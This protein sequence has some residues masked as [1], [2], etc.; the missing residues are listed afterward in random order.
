MAL[1]SL[2]IVAKAAPTYVS[3]SYGVDQIQF[4]AGGSN[5][6]NSAGYNARASLGDI[7]VGNSASAGYQAYAGFTTTE[8]PFL[9]ITVPAQTVDFGVLVPGTG[10][11]IATPQPIVIRAWLSSGYTLI[12]GS[13][14]PKY[15]S[16]F[17]NTLST[18][19]AY[20]STLE[21]FGINLVGSNTSPQTAGA[22][23]DNSSIAGLTATGNAAAG[24]NTANQYKYVKGDVI[25]SSSA[26]TSVTKYT[27]T[28]MFNANGATPAG[29]YTM[30]HDIVAVGTF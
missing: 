9:E 21:Q 23:P 1:F 18:P 20:N 24:Y 13:D 19:T 5:D 25:A 30:N 29:K 27:I 7:G 11:A 10:Q 26:S 17:F 28:Y 16:H 15:S 3:P 4:G 2:S 8:E 12:N 22:N 6:L 14:G